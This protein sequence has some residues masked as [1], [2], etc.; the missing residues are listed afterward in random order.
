MQKNTAV[1]FIKCDLD[2]ISAAAEPVVF[3]APNDKIGEIRKAA[4]QAVNICASKC[5]LLNWITDKAPSK[6]RRQGTVLECVSLG[7]L[8]CE[9]HSRDNVF[10]QIWDPSCCLD[11]SAIFTQAL[12]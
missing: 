4:L 2:Q 6:P 11:I 10:D 8:T 3:A 5:V 1:L 7:Y 9:L 12:V